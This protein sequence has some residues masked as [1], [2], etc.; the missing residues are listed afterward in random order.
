HA[1]A[2]AG[3]TSYS[4][5]NNGNMLTRTGYTFG[6]D[7]ENRLVSVSGGATASFVYDGDNNRVKGT[8]GGVT[9]VYVGNYYEVA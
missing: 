7:A 6:Y 3:G 4:Y 8:A 5:D 9:S 2:T 1:V